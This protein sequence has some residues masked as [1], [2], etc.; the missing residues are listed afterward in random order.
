[1][2]LKQLIDKDPELGSMRVTSYSHGNP[3]KAQK[4]LANGSPVT[5]EYVETTSLSI[6]ATSSRDIKG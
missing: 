4:Y 1:M 3:S 5:G 6:N 2:T